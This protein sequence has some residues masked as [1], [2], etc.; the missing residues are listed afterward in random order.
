MTLTSAE[1]EQYRTQGWLAPIDVLSERDA[2][3]L[4]GKL[5]TAERGYPAELHAENRNNAHLAF[6][7]LAELAKH[8][9]IADVVTAIV[10]ADITLWSTVLFVKEP[11]SAAFVSWHQDA[12]YMGLDP[13]DFVTAW[14]ALTPS[15]RQTGCVSVIPG[16]HSRVHEHQDTFGADNILTR[17]QSV[18]E[19]DATKAV[20]LELQPGQMSLHHPWLIHGSQ[21]NRSSQRRIGV[22]M[23]SYLGARVHPVRGI[24]HVMHIR[25]R[26]V[27][28]PFVE[29]P[30]PASECSLDA[31]AVR[32][33]ANNALADVLYNDAAERR[34]L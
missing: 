25:G 14:I 23:Q 31:M 5:E 28:A 21:P 30:A 29:A 7:F 33:A 2:L 20:H 18:A 9:T 13:D 10:G 15:T 8:P 34:D 17:G 27:S 19:V 3:A 22:A 26:P 4:A 16:S 24:H 11:D 6:P 32:A 1:L 12:F